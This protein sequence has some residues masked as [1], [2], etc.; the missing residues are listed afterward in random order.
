MNRSQEL[1]LFFYPESKISGYTSIDG[2]VEFYGRVNSL[3]DDSMTVLDFGAGR[4]SWYEDD[5]CSYRKEVRTICGKVKKLIG[6]DIDDSIFHNRSVDESVE[7]KIGES[8]PFED[9]SF[10]MIISDYTFEHVDNPEEISK[11]FSRILKPGGW[12]CARTPNKYAYTSIFTRIISNSVH[13]KLLKLVQPD[14]KEIDVFPT[15]FKLN[16][17]N[18]VSKYFSEASYKNM[19]YRHQPEPAYHFN[20]K[21]IF[22]SLMLVNKLIPSVLKTS[23]F[24][25]LQKKEL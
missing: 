3:I 4:A 7:I 8:L 11:E 15:R 21:L 25:F 24:I 2:T 14:R 19:T 20:N 6:C 17:I 1:N 16:S 23:L 9:E 22:N 13:S 10:D 18:V 5:L 12:I